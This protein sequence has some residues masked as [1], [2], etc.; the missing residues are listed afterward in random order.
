MTQASAMPLRPLVM[1]TLAVLA[2]H[3]VVLQARPGALSLSPT[4]ATGPLVTRTIILRSPPP[5]ADPGKQASAATPAAVLAAKDAPARID[6]G[7]ATISTTASSAIPI[8]PPPAAGPSAPTGAESALDATPLQPTARGTPATATAFAIP[9]SLHIRYRVVGE[10]RKQPY[11]ANAVLEW[12]HDGTSYEAKLEVGAFLIGSRL[13]RSTGR[14]GVEGLAPVRF[15]DKSR[16]EEATHFDM[17]RRRIRF[18]N[19]AP[20]VPLL[21][22]AQDRLSIF[23]QIGAMVAGDME[24][25]VAGTT[26]PV[27]TASTREADE[28]VF[29]VI[30]PEVLQLPGGAMQTLKLE[31]KPRREY[32]QKVEVWIAPAL[33]HMPARMLLTSPNGDFADLLWIAT[34]RG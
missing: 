12:N 25:F 24:R 5:T 33:E 7:S 14:I 17:E 29:V 2:L 10:S 32:D 18:S 6:S 28:W 20:D 27:Q 26:I 4:L 1:L 22:G 11:Q 8:E 15:S 21:A 16:S 23:I 31:R 19:N 9:G 3:L 34:G 13:Q 30:G